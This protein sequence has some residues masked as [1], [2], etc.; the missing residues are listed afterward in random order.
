MVA[1]GFAKLRRFKCFA[2]APFALTLL[3]VPVL[4]SIHPPVTQMMRDFLMLAPSKRGGIMP[5]VIDMVGLQ[6]ASGL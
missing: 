3:L 1:V 2:M 6:T 4:V 5:V